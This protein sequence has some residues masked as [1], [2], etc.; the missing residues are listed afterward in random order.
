MPSPALV[1]HNQQT[2][3]RVRPYRVLGTDGHDQGPP[4][5][6]IWFRIEFTSNSI[7]PICYSHVCNST[8]KKNVSEKAVSVYGYGKGAGNASREAN[9]YS[10]PLNR[11]GGETEGYLPPSFHLLSRFDLSL[12]S[13]YVL[14]H[15]F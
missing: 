1:A 10:L 6:S 14:L 8:L 4:L 15:S 2:C 5:S 13:V 12:S 7:P 9:I 3:S 11:G